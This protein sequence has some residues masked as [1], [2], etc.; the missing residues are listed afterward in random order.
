MCIK[1]TTTW[2]CAELDDLGG[3]NRTECCGR[4]V[5][6]P[7]LK[8][9][10][11]PKESIKR[12]NVWQGGIQQPLSLWP[13]TKWSRLT[14]DSGAM[15]VVVAIYAWSEARCTC[16]IPRIM[17]DFP[18][19]LPLVKWIKPTK[20]WSSHLVSFEALVNLNAFRLSWSSALCQQ[21]KATMMS[22]WPA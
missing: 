6:S 8:H 3:T 19:M 15:L 12:R 1:Q 17:K 18:P 22:I 10:S 7:W 16:I 14:L 4:W 20:G 13:Q 11:G 2:H 9:L 21:T 5:H